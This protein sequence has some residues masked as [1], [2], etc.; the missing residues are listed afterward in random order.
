MP[1][2]Q[3]IFFNHVFAKEGYIFEGSSCGW[4]AMKELLLKGIFEAVQELE[5]FAI[6]DV[7]D[8]VISRVTRVVCAVEKSGVRVDWLDRVIGEVSSR[9]D[10]AILANKESRLSNQ[11]AQLR[12]ELGRA[13]KQLG[14]V[15]AEMALRN[16]CTGVVANE[17]ICIIA[18]S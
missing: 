14:V 12:E 6:L 4:E 3:I 15:R 18:N 5:S 11:V 9:R 1:Q 17:R 13:E 2:E 7:P 10:H 16:F 8:K